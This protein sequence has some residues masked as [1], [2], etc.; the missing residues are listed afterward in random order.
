[1]TSKERVR[2]A[3]ERKPVDRIPLGFYV[4]DCDTVG[5]VLGRR[6][7]VRDKVGSQIALW[8]GR[9]DEVVES[10]KKDTVEFYRRIDCADLIT[11]KEAPFVPAKDARVDPPRRIDDETWRD[12]AGR[13]FKVSRISNEIL[14]V[15][16]PT[17]PTAEDL[18][19]EDFPEYEES[20]FRPPDPSE[21][22]A[23][24]YI[25]EQLGADRYIAGKSGEIVALTL[26]GGTTTGLMLYAL[27]PE[28]I[29][30]ANRRLTQEQNLYDAYCIRPG[31][32]GVL[33]EQDMAGSN[34]PL[35]NPV[36]FRENCLPYMAE[37]VRNVRSYGQQIILHNCGDNRPL[38][39][40][41]IDAGV[42]CYQSLQTNAGMD[43]GW[44]QDRFGHAL[45]YWGGV[46]VELLISG[47]PDDVRQNVREAME[48]GRRGP[49]FILGPSHSIAYGTKYDNFMAMLDEYDRLAD[50]V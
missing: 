23:C 6:T 32:D 14:C 44:L 39:E 49:G 31:Q 10:Y 43:V 18:D 40:M 20:E 19:E 5:R 46:S 29:R 26:P 22:E 50:Q 41:F 15:E 12:R 2:A 48:K 16:D 25:V 1:M 38:M 36:Q 30:A 34:G 3:I 45:T 7:F 24:D 42:E 28:V 17:L 37:R 21:F 13:I 11:F 47:E 35:I 27:K 4:A 9:R 8:E 33:F